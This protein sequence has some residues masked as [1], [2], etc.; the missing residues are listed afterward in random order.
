MTIRQIEILFWLAVIVWM[1]ALAF[2]LLFP[3]PAG[4]PP[5]ADDK[6]ARAARL[7]F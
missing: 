2:A 4:A 1:S 5:L 6:P 7:L 3:P